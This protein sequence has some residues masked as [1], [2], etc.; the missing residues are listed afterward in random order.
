MNSPKTICLN[1]GKS[2]H[3]VKSCD[4]P[5]ISY[6]II[7]FNI[8]SEFNISNKNMEY[9]FYNKF[10]D[11]SEF[12]Y[13]NIHNINLIP[14]FYDKIRI[15]MIRRKNSL[16]YV[17]FLRGK[18]DVTDLV[19]I[20]KLFN[21][22]TKDENI[23]I[24]ENNF[25]ELW[26]E[27]WKETAKSKIYQKEYN[28]A[29]L[30]FEELKLNNFYDLLDDDKLSNYLE[31]EWGF[32]KGRRNVYEKNINCAIREFCEETSISQENLH[33]LERV[34]YLEEEYVGTNQVKYKHIYYLGFSQ[35]QLGLNINN[36]NQLYEIGDIKWFS[37]PEAIEKIRDYNQEKIQMIYQLYFFIINLIVELT[38]I[39][40]NYSTL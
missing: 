19:H 6:G 2:G 22:M 29:K 3:Q 40:S 13:S 4:E 16:N 35:N 36:E 24:R 23:K 25:D 5:I 31:A 8:N 20:K 38:T 14:E 34:N 12:N 18:Y 30:K 37:I 11:P 15:L 26:N 7:C 17:E 27:L 32:P 33:I 28:L 9:F 21:L 1:C 39:N 10:I